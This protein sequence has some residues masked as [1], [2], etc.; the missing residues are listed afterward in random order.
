M[1][2]KRF[3]LPPKSK[4][5]SIQHPNWS[6]VVIKTERP[7]HPLTSDV[8]TIQFR[9]LQ[10]EFLELTVRMI[11]MTTTD[12]KKMNRDFVCF[13]VEIKSP[14]KFLRLAVRQ[15]ICIKHYLS[16]IIWYC[17]SKNSPSAYQ[18]FKAYSYSNRRS[19]GML[20]F[21]M[22]RNVHMFPFRMKGLKHQLKLCFIRRLNPFEPWAKTVWVK[23]MRK[24][25]ERKTRTKGRAREEEE[26]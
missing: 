4:F 25:K 15:Y 11:T 20:A 24:N 10:G 9:R 18:S 12:M 22:Y 7:Q 16:G 2:L 8:W 14:I 26:G 1:L 5:S 19:Q 3:S 17:T 6:P 23:I 21:L 13:A